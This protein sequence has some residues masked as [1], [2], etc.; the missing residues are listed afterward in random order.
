MQPLNR[1]LSAG[2]GQNVAVRGNYIWLKSSTGPVQIKTNN[3]DVAIL[4]SGEFVRLQ[5]VF[6]D[7]FL[8]DLS[9]SQNDMT[10]VVSEGGDAGKFGSV[11]ILTPTSLN[12]Y[13]DVTVV[14]STATLL[15]AASS[16]RTEVI[17]S[18]LDTNINTARIG[19]ASVTGSRG[20]LLPVGASI[21]LST[22]AAVYCFAND[23]DTFSII[24]MGL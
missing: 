7:F 19:T 3:G 23:A 13:N 16:S 10:L 12:D 15:I 11:S 1:K 18:S 21:T 24:E 4:N 2:S 8:Q 9:A 14:A 22:A 20:A 5:K 6:D 17:I